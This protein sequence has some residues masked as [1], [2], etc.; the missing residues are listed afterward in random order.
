ME[1]LPI[2]W[3]KGKMEEVTRKVKFLLL[4]ASV[5][6]TDAGRWVEDTKVIELTFPKELGKKTCVTSE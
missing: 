1:V 5:P 4:L 2:V 3:L 6:Q